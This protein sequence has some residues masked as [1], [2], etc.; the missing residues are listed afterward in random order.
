MEGVVLS[1]LRSLGITRSE[2]KSGQAR[3]EIL[4]L[5][6]SAEAAHASAK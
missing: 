5:S 1:T 3:N 6:D 2:L 4:P